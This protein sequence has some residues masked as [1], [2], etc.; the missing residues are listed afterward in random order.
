MRDAL[1]V[2]QALQVWALLLQ[3]LV[4]GLVLQP[5]WAQPPPAQ[6]Q[7]LQQPNAL[8]QVCCTPD[9]WF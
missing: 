9:T 8:L 7:A 1:Q 4:Q 5:V 6:G 3:R 2:L